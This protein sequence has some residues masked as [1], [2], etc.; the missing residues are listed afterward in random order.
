[1]TRLIAIVVFMLCAAPAFAAEPAQKYLPATV[2]SLSNALFKIGVLRASDPLAVDEYVRIHHC[3]LYEQY[4]AEDVAWTRIREAQARE[5]SLITPSFNEYVELEGSVKLANYDFA[6]GRF[7]FSDDTA[8]RN[9]GLVK[10]ADYAGGRYEPCVGRQYNVFVP[11]AHPMRLTA[12]LSQPL[13]LSDIPL[14]R[15]EADRLI[16]SFNTRVIQIENEPTRRQ[17]V[18]VMRLRLNGPDPLSGSVDPASLT[19]TGDLDEIQI[20]ED[21]TREKLLYSEKFIDRSAVKKKGQ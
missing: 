1:M 4:G 3:G 6:A 13:T 11:R 16:K 17:V 7:A 21:V 5:L 12:R 8:L 9:M 10:I 2:Q 20:F 18:M 14:S 19:V 15:T